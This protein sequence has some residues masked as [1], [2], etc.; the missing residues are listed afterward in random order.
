M[1]ESPLSI[2]RSSAQNCRNVRALTLTALFV[3]LNITLD[4]MNV[5][6]QLTPQLRIGFG[7]LCN[8]AVGMLYGPVP[9]IMAG[10]CTDTLGY[11]MNS[12]GG[13]YFPGYTI[14][15]MVG[16]LIYGLVLYRPSQDRKKRM[17]RCFIAKGCANLF[18]NIIIN[19]FWLSMTGGDAYTALL[20]LR[21]GKNLA[22]WP[23][24]SL[25]LFTVMEI[26]R[27]I[28]LQFPD[29]RARA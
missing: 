7:Y 11:L 10:F 13:A 14:T 24:E 19:T 16:G 27:E 5:R 12:G 20:P 28:S 23:I 25:L 3:A 2:F 8:A 6:V 21:I 22:L 1:K 17:L 26:V 4:L 29:H 9:T 18:C 15:A